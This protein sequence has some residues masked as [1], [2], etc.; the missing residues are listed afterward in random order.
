MDASKAEK[1][2]SFETV[3]KI[4]GSSV[5]ENF[6]IVGIA[7][8]SEFGP[9]AAIAS[10]V[11]TGMIGMHFGGEIGAMIGKGIDERIAGNHDEPASPL[12]NKRGYKRNK[13]G[14]LLNN[15]RGE[16]AANALHCMENPDAHN[17]RIKEQQNNVTR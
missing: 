2:L 15:S 9:L 12:Q 7:V 10:G 14:N 6:S 3:G 8:G 5:G 4:V 17:R 11:V 1:L 13:S 16:I